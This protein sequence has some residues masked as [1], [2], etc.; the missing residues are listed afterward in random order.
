MRNSL[1]PSALVLLASVV[2]PHADP[3]IANVYARTHTSL[4]GKWHVIVDPYDNGYYDY[5][6]EPWDAQAAPR[7]GYFLDRR[8]TDK[9][10]LQEY[11]FEASPTLTVPGD[12]NSQNEKFLYYEGTMWYERRFEAPKSQP[13]GR[14]FL[15]FG[16]ANYRAD[17]YVN[18][19]KLGTHIGGFTPFSYE[20][21]SL[22]HDHDNSVVSRSTTPGT[23]T[24]FPRTTPTGGITADSPATCSWSNCRQR[25]SA[26]S[27][28]N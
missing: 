18:G 3:A 10:V 13:D 11:N 7:G 6:H 1:V 21:T 22:V 16:A 8:L 9:T 28:S 17:V 24:A 4:N 19:H 2:T 12:W 25:S 14:L 20:V 5:R 26:I 15:Y 23:P 27:A